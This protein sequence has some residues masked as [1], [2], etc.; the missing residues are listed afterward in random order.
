ME[1][2]CTFFEIVFLYLLIKSIFKTYSTEVML[3]SNQL[4][5]V[6][7]ALPYAACLISQWRP[8]LC[9]PWTVTYQAPLSVEILQEGILEWVAMPSSRGSS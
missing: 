1:G 5:N 2:S 4:S 8:T 7:P 3:Y 6:E 9:D